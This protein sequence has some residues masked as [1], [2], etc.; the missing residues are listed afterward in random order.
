MTDNALVEIR[1]R[2]QGC[3]LKQKPPA[4][5]ST[6]PT[7][8]HNIFQASHVWLVPANYAYLYYH[9]VGELS[10]PCSCPPIWQE[11]TLTTVKTKPV[12]LVV[13]RDLGD[14]PKHDPPLQDE[15]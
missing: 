3:R 13:Q 6:E 15:F 11:N 1:T 2:F 7:I 8:V 12:I 4:E 5:G 10:R 9:L 14:L